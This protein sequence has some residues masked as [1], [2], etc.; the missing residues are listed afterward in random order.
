MTDELPGPIG[1]LAFSVCQTICSGLDR[2]VVAT[3]EAVNFVA[4]QPARVNFQQV[5]IMPDTTASV[6]ELTPGPATP[7]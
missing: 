6:N 4:S 2:N 1:A 7:L 5:T 3:A